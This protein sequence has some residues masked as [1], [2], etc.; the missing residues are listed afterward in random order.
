MALILSKIAIDLTKLCV[1]SSID[2]NMCAE[3]A[4]L[5]KNN[6]R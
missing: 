1:N 3:Y 4:K 6:A 2:E 5:G